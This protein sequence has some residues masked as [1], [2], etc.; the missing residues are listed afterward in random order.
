MIFLFLAYVVFWLV[1]A[2]LSLFVPIG[3]EKSVVR[4]LPLVT[5]GIMLV[6]VLAYYVSM[7]GTGV[8]QI[9][10]MKE[11]GKLDG[12]LKTNAAIVADE[13]VQQKLMGVAL[14]S[15]AEAD[16]IKDQLKDNPKLKSQ[17][18]EW[19]ASAE[20]A[21]IR[22]E[23]NK[24]VDAIEAT[25]SDM[26]DYR[27]GLSPNGNWKIYQLIT[28]AF[29]HGSASHLY[30][31]LLFFFSIAFVLEDLWGRG[32]FLGFYLSG[33]VA[34][35]IP[36][37]VSPA[38]VPLIGASG[39][40]SAAMGAFLVRLPKTKI[41]LVFWPAKVLALLAKRPMSVMVP[42]YVFL[43]F[44]F[45]KNIIEW[46]MDYKSGST[47]GTAFS[48]HIAGFIFGAAFAGVMRLSKYEETHIHPKLEAKV[49]FAASQAVQEGLDMMDK[50]QFE[51]AEH[52]LR[53]HLT[54]NFDDL[55]AILALIHIY[56][57]QQ[58]YDQL[59]AMYG[60]LIHYHLKRN[61]KEAAL[62][63]YD[64]LLSAFPDNDIRARIPPRDWM[65]I[66]DYLCEVQMVREA[67]VEYER[68]ANAWPNDASTA[69]VLVQGAECA[70]FAMDP[71]RALRMFEA[72]DK[73]A[74]PQALAAKINIG[75]EKCRRI[76][77][78]HPHFKKRNQ[79]KKPAWT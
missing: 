37:L 19:L 20:A 3:N 39:A 8:G 28:A 16:E 44:F 51:G 73:L 21:K 25:R 64:N 72:A 61:D 78:N 56:E 67:A 34:A 27:F 57:K 48:A 30:F 59:N 36:F 58:N 69:R 68:L 65:A 46:Y 32:V 33:A 24:Q 22:E 29:M 77:E 41:K 54:Q 2:F 18:D 6:C 79:P 23:L 10:L 42:S 31:N 53:S 7:P 43:L 5:F 62:V 74:P 47:S 13:K 1:F 17:Y 63:A 76:I 60:R 26:P 14:M 12:F 9:E 75:T 35:C 71:E 50:G 66:C 55:E 52:K 4:R 38:P 15:Q 45:V 11:L 70:L 49:S 40:I